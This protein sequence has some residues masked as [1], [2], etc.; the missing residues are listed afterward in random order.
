[1][2][3][4]HHDSTVSQQAQEN[5]A[6]RPRLV[7]GDD[8]SPSADQVW[9]WVNNHHWTGWR[10]S[11]LTARRPSEAAPVGLERAQPHVWQPEHPRELING[12]D[13]PVEHLLAEEDPRLALDCCHDAGLLAIGP[14]GRGLHKR[15]H[16]GSTAEWLVST[17]RPL[18][19]V[20]IIRSPRQTERIL[21]CVDG[22]PNSRRAVTSLTALPWVAGCRVQ[23][24]GVDERGDGFVPTAVDDT[25]SLLDESGVSDVSSVVMG[26]LP[27]TVFDV[28]AAILTTIDDMAPD[29]VALGARG[30]GGFAGLF[31]GS[32]AS[33]VVHHAPCSVLVAP[34]RTATQHEGPPGLTATGH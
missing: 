20:A 3:T 16:I 25:A 23:V 34:S 21:L 24:L 9:S 13:V 33:A 31:I 19:P 14:R 28:R 15:L 17:G 26:A 8:G 27:G 12:D 2:N 30:T 4:T 7:V 22:S 18:A 11:V 32:V 5:G 6:E 29:L 10:I 1:M